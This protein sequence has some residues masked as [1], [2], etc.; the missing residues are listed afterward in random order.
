MD[1]L[2]TVALAGPVTIAEAPRWREELA[3]AFAAATAVRLDLGESGPW[4][5][6]GL[7][8]LI[9]SQA[10][11]RKEGDTLEIVRVPR[12]CWS[13]AESA[14]LSAALSPVVASHLE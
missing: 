5:L 6:S 4:D 1:T 9:S 12:S 8:L 7:Q 11:A 3:A 10:Q 13:L 2:V 14:G